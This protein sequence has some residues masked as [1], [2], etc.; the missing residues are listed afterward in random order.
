MQGKYVVRLVRSP[1]L[2]VVILFLL[3]FVIL[4]S[5]GI[6]GSS[7]G[8]GLRESGVI[9]GETSFLFGTKP[10]AIR[11]DEWL[12][13]TPMAIGQL[14]HEP[15]FPIENGNLGPNGQNMLVVGMTG[16]PVA[17]I[18]VIGRPATWGFF[19][20]DLKRAL[21]WYWWL[22]IFGSLFSIWGLVSVGFKLDWLSALGLASLVV[23]SPYMTGWSYWPAYAVMFPSLALLAILNIFLTKLTCLRV[24]WAFI[25]M[26]AT[27]GFFLVLYPAW[28]IPLAYLYLCMFIAIFIRDRLWNE[29][30][31]EKY[32]LIFIALF[33]AL[34]VVF[35]WWIEAKD[36]IL[37]MVSTIYPGQR[38]EVRG[39]NLPS[40]FLVKGLVSTWTMFF[41]DL[42]GTN[43]SASAS[44][45]YFLIPSLVLFIIATRNLNIGLLLPGA[46]LVFMAITLIYQNYGFGLNIAKYTLWGRTTA[47][48]SDLALGV[49]QFL[50][51]AAMMQ[52]FSER[53]IRFKSERS[54]LIAWSVAIFSTVVALYGFSTMPPEWKLHRAFFCSQ[55]LA[56]AIVGLGTYLLV[57]KLFS[58]FILIILSAGLIIA[59]AFNPVFISP[60]RIVPLEFANNSVQDGLFKFADSGRTLVIGSQVPAMMLFAS[61]VKVLNGVHYYPQQSIWRVFDPLGSRTNVYNRYQHYYCLWFVIYLV[62]LPMRFLRR[63][64]MWFMLYWIGNVTHFSV[65]P[66]NQVLGSAA[67]EPYLRQ[68]QSLTYVGRVGSMSLF[69][70]LGEVKSSDMLDTVI[71]GER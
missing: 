16:V 54:K 38:S 68:N 63:K 69:R 2:I 42:P 21:A 24:L 61:G 19:F 43:K 36:A 23:F 34:A 4:V 32:L 66:I 50:F 51:I 20:L 27:T 10:L 6:T 7:L 55:F 40:W 47:D 11:S 22:P 17:H 64:K 44:F 1:P 12:V 53:K 67:D 49:A 29:G 57:L 33:A 13:T 60:K 41:E 18:S 58:T 45:Y 59:V 56:L 37:S 62:T 28:Q 48:R 5:A 39:G 8:L 52:Y 14:N 71:G 46:I 15:P 30:S 26:L 31:M 9:E 3:A 65:L 35:F 70:V 25:L